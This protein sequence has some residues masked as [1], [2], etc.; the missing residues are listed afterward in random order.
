MVHKAC[1]APKQGIP[2]Q[3]EGINALEKLRMICS[4]ESKKKNCVPRE[5]IVQYQYRSL[6]LL[7]P[8]WLPWPRLEAGPFLQAKEEKGEM[9]VSSTLTHS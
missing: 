2:I 5:P 8:P 1:K 4:W 6:L 7:F 9:N 3:I